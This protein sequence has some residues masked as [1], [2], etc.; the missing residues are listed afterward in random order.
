MQ[1]KFMHTAAPTIFN[2]SFLD[3]VLYEISYCVPE[4]LKSWVWW[5]CHNVST[6]FVLVFKPWI[7]STYC[8]MQNCIWVG[9]PSIS[10]PG[11]GDIEWGAQPSLWSTGGH[12]Q[13]WCFSPEL[14]HKWWQTGL[15]CHWPGH[16]VPAHSLHSQ[17]C[18]GIWQIC[19]EE[20]ALPGRLRSSELWYSLLIC[21]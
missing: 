11:C 7:M 2:V 12:P 20:L 15:V 3:M 6:T 18:T 1:S 17:A 8:I 21:T 10:G 14:P 16:L 4:K 9:E 5:V 13:P 19:P